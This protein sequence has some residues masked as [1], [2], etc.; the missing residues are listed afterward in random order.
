MNEVDYSHPSNIESPSTKA[1]FSGG[2]EEA[3]DF[4]N[5]FDSQ[6]NFLFP[7]G[8]GDSSTC[9]EAEW[10]PVDFDL[11][12]KSNPKWRKKKKNNHNSN[13]PKR[14]EDIRLS[15]L[16][17]CS[18]NEEE[19]E[20][21]T[22]VP[23]SCDSS[24][25]YEEPDSPW[26]IF[27]KAKMSSSPADG[28]EGEF[29]SGDPEWNNK[30]RSSR[31]RPSSTSSNRKGTSSRR[32]EQ[33]QQLAE[34]RRRAKEELAADPR[35]DQSAES[36]DLDNASVS[37]S[38]EDDN[39]DDG[40]YS[41]DES[42]RSYTDSPTYNDDDV[43][44]MVTPAVGKAKDTRKKPPTLKRGTH[45][46][47]TP[48][49]VKALK[50]KSA[51]TVSDDEGDNDFDFDAECDSDHDSVASG[52]SRKSKGERENGSRKQ[53]SF[54]IPSGT[55]KK[56]FKFDRNRSS[57]DL[58]AARKANNSFKG[59]QIDMNKSLSRLNRSSS[60]RMEKMQGSFS[61]SSRQGKGS[62]SKSSGMDSKSSSSRKVPERAQSMHNPTTGASK[63]KM[64]L[65]K[66]A[67]TVDEPPSANAGKKNYGATLSALKTL[68]GSIGGGKSSDLATTIMQQVHR[69]TSMNPIELKIK[70]KAKMTKQN[71]LSAAAMS[72][73]AAA[74]GDMLGDIPKDSKSSKKEIRRSKTSHEK[75]SSEFN[76]SYHESIAKMRKQKMADASERSAATLASQSSDNKEASFKERNVGRAKSFS[77]SSSRL[78][79]DS[80]M[81]SPGK[82]PGKSP[83]RSPKRPGLKK[84][85]SKRGFDGNSSR[86]GLERV[87]SVRRK[88]Y[89]A[90]H[91][92]PTG[93]NVISMLKDNKKI[94]DTEMMQKGNRQMFH[95]LMFKTRMGIDM[96]ALKRKVEGLDDDEEEE[97]EQQ[98]QYDDDGSG[99]DYS[100]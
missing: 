51:F 19:E 89:D 50:D 42:D 72:Q 92:P 66:F 30:S 65:A 84:G 97:E 76:A 2:G 61:S 79:V 13:K 26:A 43:D 62:S 94:T 47:A 5:S 44:V 99:S 8:A 3:I 100:R 6:L 64:G 10:D 48:S 73:A 71:S 88:E 4:D 15:R 29:S 55:A 75:S 17:S 23:T 67:G 12:K 96:D 40:D 74:S 93:P 27:G 81:V 56:D 95:M 31:R 86:R 53:Q 60:K 68:S 46:V 11:K 1:L 83:G 36:Y 20:T 33:A 59:G 9:V 14:L 22:A 38:D 54:R 35:M 24:W 41:E 32:F 85:A 90:S 69:S 28:F 70:P 16:D 34:E 78:S 7:E 87:A 25:P 49:V 37:D 80:A 21:A 39:D 98:Q 57:R 18:D 52:H 58:K 82:S 77:A 45:Q 63:L 91:Q